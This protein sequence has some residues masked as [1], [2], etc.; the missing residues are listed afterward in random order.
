NRIALLRA[1]EAA[2]RAGQVDRATR[3]LDELAEFLH[4]PTAL[5][6]YHRLHGEL[7]L[8]RGEP[9]KSVDAGLAAIDALP[10]GDASEA[11]ARAHLLLGK[12]HHDAGRL[13][14]SLQYLDRGADLAARGVAPAA[15]LAHL[16]RDRGNVH[17]KLG[18]P[19]RALDAYEQA[20]RAAEDA[21]DLE[22]L[23]IA[24]MGL[25]VAA[26]QRGDAASSIGHAE[27]AIALLERLEMRRLS[28]Q[29]LTN[30]GHAHA[31]RG[32]TSEA[33]A[34]QLRAIEASRAIGERRTEGY[35]LERLSAL[36][37]AEGQAAAALGHAREA[38]AA[39]TEV[40]DSDL[41]ALAIVV[42]AEA[43][44][45]AGDRAGANAHL[46][47]AR[48]VMPAATVMVRRAIL[49]RHGELHR[50]RG[51]HAHASRS[52]EEAARLGMPAA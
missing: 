44:E 49:L 26:R 8:L 27:R 5:A 6:E 16:H 28:V 31:D 41:E 33:R 21:E 52:F 11:A 50:S 24:E 23:A 45:A 2:I 29:L 10:P 20:R 38:E 18:D 3:M 25:G 1:T 39:A 43:A 34:Y 30:I 12:A 13:A 14:A 37:V 32:E 9:D 46:D 35:A 51:D 36:E 19:D 15:L 22:Q 47:R 42:E 17:L 48:A 40:G 4:T 7:H